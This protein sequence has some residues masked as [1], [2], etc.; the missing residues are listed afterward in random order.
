MG[1]PTISA[2]A[3]ATVPR[4]RNE[5][6]KRQ[7]QEKKRMSSKGIEGILKTRTRKKSHNLLGELLGGGEA[8][9]PAK[10]PKT[11]WRQKRKLKMLQAA[12]EGAMTGDSR[13]KKR[14]Q[15][16]RP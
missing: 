3:N 1:H 11:D 4:V 2:R 7:D 5:R 6:R 12:S 14:G 15:G 8:P 9:D 10:R 13:Q 16:N